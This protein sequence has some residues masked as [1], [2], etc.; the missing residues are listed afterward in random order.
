MHTMKDFKFP[1]TLL[2]VEC[3]DFA[4]LEVM[5]GDRARPDEGVDILAVGARRRGSFIAL[6]FLAGGLNRPGEWAFPQRLAV[7]PDAQQDEVVAL[8]AGQKDAITP[9]N[10]RR[11]HLARQGQLPDDVLGFAPADRQPVAA[12][13]AVTVRP[14]P[15]RPVIRT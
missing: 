8:G 11:S 14:A 1:V 12:R 13:D 3:P 15:I 2:G 4:A 6:I 5:A 10:R 9:D 7:G